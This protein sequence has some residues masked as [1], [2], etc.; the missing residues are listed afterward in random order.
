[1]S[2]TT[3]NRLI[4]DY[5]DSIGYGFESEIIPRSLAGGTKYPFILLKTPKSDWDGAKRIIKYPSTIYIVGDAGKRDVNELV[6]ELQMCAI[7]IYDAL[8]SNKTY[9]DRT[10]SCDPMTD[11]DN[12]T[13]HGIAVTLNIYYDGGC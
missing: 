8:Q 4:K 13:A 1:M 11:F 12:T 9:T 2:R 3:I 6:D 10:F 7:G 5:A